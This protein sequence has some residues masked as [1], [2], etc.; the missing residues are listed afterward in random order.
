MALRKRPDGLLILAGV[1]IA[2]FVIV[3]ALLMTGAF[4]HQTNGDQINAELSEK[5]GLAGTSD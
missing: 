3:S 4:N 1:A 2:S 5:L